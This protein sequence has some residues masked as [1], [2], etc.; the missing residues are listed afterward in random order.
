MTGEIAFAAMRFRGNDVRL[1][2]VLGKDVRLS[3]AIWENDVPR[4]DE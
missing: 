1:N 3:A 4:N 2:D